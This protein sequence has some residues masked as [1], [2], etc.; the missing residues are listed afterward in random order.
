MYLISRIKGCPQI[1][2]NLY[3]IEDF[4]PEA[5]QLSNRAFY[6]AMMQSSVEF[7]LNTEKKMR[8]TSSAISNDKSRQ[9]IEKIRE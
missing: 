1:I 9:N 7:L 6:L 2:A 4:L 5:V 8:N 3:L